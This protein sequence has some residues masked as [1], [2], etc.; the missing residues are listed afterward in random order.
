MNKDMIDG[1]WRSLAKRHKPQLGQPCFAKRS[2]VQSVFCMASPARKLNLG[3]PKSPT[4]PSSCRWIYRH[5]KLCS[6]SRGHVLSIRRE[7]PS[8]N[9]LHI[10]IKNN[11]AKMSPKVHQLGKVVKGEIIMQIDLSNPSLARQSFLHTPFFRFGVRED[12][13]CKCNV[14]RLPPFRPR[15]LPKKCQLTVTHRDRSGGT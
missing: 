8:D 4:P 7:L 14:L 6:V 9:I 15:G 12:E 10:I 2:A 11:A 3:V 13:K 1:F 5:Q